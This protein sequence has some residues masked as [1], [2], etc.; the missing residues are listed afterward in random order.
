M[1]VPG[2][3]PLVDLR[4]N[5][6]VDLRQA[7]LAVTEL[8]PAQSVA[9]LLSN[10][11]ACP[12]SERS[13]GPPDGPAVSGHL[14]DALRVQPSPDQFPTQ[15]RHSILGL[16]ADPDFLASDEGGGSVH[17]DQCDRGCHVLLA[18]FALHPA[19][20]PHRRAKSPLLG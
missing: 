14:H 20:A 3:L 11:Q 12:V 6:Q 10:R 1:I 17:S 7:A 4:G 9:V 16:G 5:P 13:V 2:V 8:P 18:V 15:G 19:F